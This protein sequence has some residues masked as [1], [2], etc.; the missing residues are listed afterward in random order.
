M[1]M[2][3]HT[4]NPKESTKNVSANKVEHQAYKTQDQIIKNN[5]NSIYQQQAKIKKTIPSKIASKIKY[6]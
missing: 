4:E 2:I 3:L 6:K 1:N 5:Y